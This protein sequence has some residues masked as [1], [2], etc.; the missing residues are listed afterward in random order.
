[1]SICGNIE[2]RRAMLNEKKEI[3]L[4][5][6]KCGKHVSDYFGIRNLEDFYKL[7][8]VWVVS[9]ERIIAFAVAV[10]LKRTPTISLYEIGVDPEHRQKG[11]AKKLL[12]H[13][14]TIYPEREYSFVV[15]ESNVEGRATYNK[16]GFKV[17]RYDV[18]KS[19][20]CIVRM[21]GKL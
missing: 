8:H 16:L 20:R 7:G 1:M 13:I 14:Q 2:I 6:K 5:V 15:N 21:S 3:D 12:Q 19:G 10:P 11:H 9:G 4:L 18:T 17:D